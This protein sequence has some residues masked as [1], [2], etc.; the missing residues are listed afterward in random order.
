MVVWQR[1]VLRYAPVIAV[2]VVATAFVPAT[3]SPSLAPI[4]GMTFKLK[5]VLKHTPTSGRAP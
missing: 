2:A 4:P 1:R 5:V 3:P